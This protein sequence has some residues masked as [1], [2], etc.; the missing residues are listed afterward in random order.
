M[1]SYKLNLSAAQLM[2]RARQIT[3]IDS[4]DTDIQEAL[5]RLVY[6]LDNEARLSEAGARGMENR[7]LTILC[8]RLRMQRDFDRYPEI[9][10]EKIV[11]PHILTGAG[12]SGSTKMHKLLAASGDFKFLRFWQQYNPALRTGRRIEDPSERV[13][14]ADDFTRW[15]N[16]RVPNARLIHA[17]ETF[18][19]EEETFL[20]DHARF[21]INF[22]ITHA[23]LPSYVQ[24]FMGQDIVKQL[25][26]VKQS[27]KYLQWQFHA[28]DD[29]PWVLKNPLY[30]G[31][32]PVLEQLFP[33]AV[34]IATHRDPASRVSSSAGLV[35]NFKKAYSDVDRTHEAGPGM[36]EFMAEAANQYLAGR[37]AHPATKILDIGYGELTADSQQV[38]E[39]IY[40]FAGRPL[41]DQVREAVARW[42][43]E[44]HQHKHGVYKY[45][46]AD[47]GITPE[48]VEEKFRP[49]VERFR[50]YL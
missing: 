27:V 1:T 31:L 48:M 5:E 25:E 14:E 6:A 40:A 9:D 38:V 20:F 30:C 37:D 3:A 8:N 39:K 34:L 49:Y 12:R 16:E 32:E 42:E 19:P 35:T 11:R 28:D 10:D 45:S 41:K 36:L 24:W 44:N 23:T 18:E 13:R 33:G 2:A 7:I 50:A 47:Y 15:F 21:G 26:F 22:N 43:A 29:R 4:V 46:L 17:Y